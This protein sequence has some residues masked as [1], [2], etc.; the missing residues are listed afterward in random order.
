MNI[1]YNSFHEQK[2][3]KKSTKKA[4]KL[5]K[6]KKSFDFKKNISLGET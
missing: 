6:R 4:K 1:Q 3:K 5:Q 2:F